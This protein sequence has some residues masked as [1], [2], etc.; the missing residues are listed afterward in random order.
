[1]H[2]YGRLKAVCLGMPADGGAWTVWKGNLCDNDAYCMSKSVR[3]Q[4]PGIGG[5][6][7]NFQK[8]KGFMLN[9]H[10]T[11]SSK[12]D[13]FVRRMKHTCTSLR[14]EREPLMCVLISHCLLQS[15]LTFW[16]VPSSSVLHRGLTPP[17]PHITFCRFVL[18][19]KPAE[20]VIA[21]LSLVTFSLFQ[22]MTKRS[23]FSLPLH[24]G[25][26]NRSLVRLKDKC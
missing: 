1:M 21:L 20:S 24:R 5:I 17:P 12:P 26:S 11:G 6:K 19:F 10:S 22:W 15:M 7:Q 23:R 4:G 25:I 13:P 3:M 14:E 16:S 2:H 9:Q 8:R 18:L